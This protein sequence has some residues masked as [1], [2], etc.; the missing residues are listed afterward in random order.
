MCA[1]LSPEIVAK[2]LHF[3]FDGSSFNY[4]PPVVDKNAPRLKASRVPIKS[5]LANLIYGADCLQKNKPPDN[6]DDKTILI[7]LI[8]KNK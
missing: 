7:K 1:K 5:L 2:F 8:Q 3:V 6:D 4:Q